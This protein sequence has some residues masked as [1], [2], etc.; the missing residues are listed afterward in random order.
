MCQVGGIAAGGIVWAGEE[1]LEKVG[2]YVRIETL[3]LGFRPSRHSRGE[4]GSTQR[5]GAEYLK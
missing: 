5:K 4:K 2:S 1:A 3:L